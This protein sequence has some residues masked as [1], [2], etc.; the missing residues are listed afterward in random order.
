MHVILPNRHLVKTLILWSKA[1]S[2]VIHEIW[3]TLYVELRTSGSCLVA[4]LTLN[5]CMADW[6]H[7]LMSRNIWKAAHRF[8]MKF[9][10]P[11]RMLSWECP[12]VCLFTGSCNLRL[13]REIE[14]FVLFTFGYTASWNVFAHKIACTWTNTKL[15]RHCCDQ[16]RL[17]CQVLCVP[18]SC[19]RYPE[20]IQKAIDSGKY[21]YFITVIAYLTGSLLEYSYAYCDD[22]L[23]FLDSVGDISEESRVASHEWCNQ[24]QWQQATS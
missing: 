1:I 13:C 5:R 24:I 3:L 7:C 14:S 21:S 4:S 18:E 16:L 10:F 15:G 23:L 2:P 17:H 6:K 11:L 9:S 20:N 22:L 8:C 12:P 19:I